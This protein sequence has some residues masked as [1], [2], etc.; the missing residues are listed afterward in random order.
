MPFPLQVLSVCIRTRHACSC[1]H[2]ELHCSVC[3][4]HGC[5][6]LSIK[7]GSFCTRASVCP[8]A[9]PGLLRMALL[10]EAGSHSA[11][12]GSV[13]HSVRQVQTRQ[14]GLLLRPGRLKTVRSVFMLHCCQ[15]D[16]LWP[17]FSRLA[18]S[19]SLSCLLRVRLCPSG[20]EDMDATPSPARLGA[21]SSFF[22]ALPSAHRSGR[23][24]SRPCCLPCSTACPQAMV[25]PL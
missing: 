5:A 15:V 11:A 16:S 22:S 20:P 2:S 17:S 25:T 3:S 7:V 13:C 23:V 24:G 9:L 8:L 10:Q 12:A 19:F 14:F 18:Q 4:S 21:F 1:L 6:D